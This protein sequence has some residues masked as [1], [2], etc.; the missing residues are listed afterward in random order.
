MRPG[1]QFRYL[2]ATSR[3]I[4]WAMNRTAKRAT[5]GLIA[6]VLVGTGL[7]TA[8]HQPLKSRA[9]SATPRGSGNTSG[10]APSGILKSV[11]DVI[12]QS[13][14]IVEGRVTNVGEPVWNSPDGTDWTKQFD[15][16]PSSYKTS[17]ITVLPMTITVDRILLEGEAG[18]NARQG[19]EL[20]VVFLS[21]S[22][23]EDDQAVFFLDSTT[24]QMSEGS[25][26]ILFCDGRQGIWRV[27]NDVATPESQ[28]QGY[29][30]ATAI[31]NGLVEG[32]VSKPTWIG[33]L[34]IDTLRDIAVE[35]ARKPGVDVAG[36]DQWPVKLAQ[37]KAARE[38]EAQDP[39]ANPPPSDV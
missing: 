7:V 22:L 28:Q 39:Q 27:E 35:E 37:D 34:E 10:Y 36:F 21:T 15:S 6:T 23:S 16:S 4:G 13:D 24:L 8:L 1:R 14:A 3:D 29:S 19:E 5:F 18:L 25:R 12:D 30:V 32:E 20:E 17:P 26:G 11:G 38:I 2:S 31:L 9:L 33:S